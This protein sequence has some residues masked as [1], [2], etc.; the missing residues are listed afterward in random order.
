MAEVDLQRETSS[1]AIVTDLLYLPPM[2]IFF[3]NFPVVAISDFIS[4]VS[5]AGELATTSAP[6][7]KSRWF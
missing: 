7:S 5:S 1:P 6:E 4:T 2:P 3:S